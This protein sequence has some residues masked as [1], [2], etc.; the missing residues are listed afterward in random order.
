[1]PDTN[2]C[3]QKDECNTLY[4]IEAKENFPGRDT[5][6]RLCKNLAVV[7]RELKIYYLYD[8]YGSKNSKNGIKL[9]KDRKKQLK[10]MLSLSLNEII[11]ISGESY[12]GIETGNSSSYSTMYDGRSGRVSPGTYIVSRR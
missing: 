10:Q 12:K 4:L 11:E 3:M 8:D 9:D 2:I 7:A 6:T 1:M 5:N